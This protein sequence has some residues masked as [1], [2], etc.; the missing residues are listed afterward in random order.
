MP[1]RRR[2]TAAVLGTCV[3]TLVWSSP[4]SAQQPV[5]TDLGAVTISGL[6]DRVVWSEPTGTDR[7]YRLMQ[8]V[9][10]GPAA[11]VA[12][13]P[14][15]R[16]PFDV[17]LGIDGRG[18]LV[19]VYSRCARQRVSEPRSG[20]PFPRLDT[21]S[22]CAVHQ[23]RFA[24]ERERLLRRPPRNRSEYLPS[25]W[26]AKL[27]VVQRDE[28]LRRSSRR[29]VRIAIVDLRSG[30][31][32]WEQ[33]G[34][35]SAYVPPRAGGGRTGTARGP[36]PIGLDLRDGRLT[37]SWAVEPRYCAGM[38]RLAPTL[39]QVWLNDVRGRGHRL[40]DQECASFIAAGSVFGA[41]LLGDGGVLYARNRPPAS[42]PSL[43]AGRV[44]L[45]PADGG[46][47]TVLGPPFLLAASTAGTDDRLYAA[48]APGV[49]VVVVAPW[50]LPGSWPASPAQ[51]GG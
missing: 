1:V 5:A 18:R 27:A 38:N 4:T 50:P 34:T 45:R 26:G 32:R 40:V 33:G 15:R 31:R 42:D 29:A 49:D 6:G 43:P 28:R 36:G 39:T 14:T 24:D 47:K 23:Y 21:A 16:G 17:E 11:P 2:L 51:R 44:V 19:A 10:G 8:S 46:P 48:V 37:Y 20:S 35:R 30:R 12:G 13:V 7:R 41:T 3:A 9:D 25:R 22:G